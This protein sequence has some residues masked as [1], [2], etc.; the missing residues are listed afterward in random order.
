MGF[1]VRDVMEVFEGPLLLKLVDE[2]LTKDVFCALPRVLRG[3]V[4]LPLEVV[5]RGAVL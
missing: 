4:S 1:D 3:R 5:V 2:V